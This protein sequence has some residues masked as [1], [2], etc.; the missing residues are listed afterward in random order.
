MN[1]ISNWL[2]ALALLAGPVVTGATPVTWELNATLASGGSIVGPLMNDLPINMT[3]G[4]D[5]VIT[6]SVVGD[7]TITDAT[8]SYAG[9]GVQPFGIEWELLPGNGDYVLLSAQCVI[10]NCLTNTTGSYV[11]APSNSYVENVTTDI[12][13]RITA[14]SFSVVPLPAAA[15]LMLSALG[16]IGAFACKRRMST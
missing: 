15:W 1:T 7:F 11:L 9:T 13:D 4:R 14:G 8:D 2:A 16:G 6:S 10:N 5:I 3:S 12:V